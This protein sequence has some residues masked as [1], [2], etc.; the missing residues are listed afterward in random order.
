MTE[1]QT[2]DYMYGKYE[3]LDLEKF[4]CGGDTAHPTK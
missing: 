4:D 2:W 3:I 1:T